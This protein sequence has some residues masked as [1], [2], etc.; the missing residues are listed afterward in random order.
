MN[1]HRFRPTLVM[2][3][4]MAACSA[5]QAQPST[6]DAS[7]S[8][9]VG[10]ASGDAAGR[11]LFGQYNGLRR[12]STI[13]LLDAEY[14]R[15]ND[16]AG[17]STQ[18]SA[19]NLL[20][21]T[22]E[23]RFGW[24]H[25]GDWKFAAHY[26][27]GVREDPLAASNGSE[28]K[29]TRTQFGMTYTKT[30]SRQ[31]QLELGLSSEKKE[32]ARLFGIGFSCPSSLAPTCRGSTGTETGWALLMLPEPIDA[33]HGQIEARLSFAGEQLRASVGYHASFYRNAL[34]S[35]QP[36]VPSSLN[37]ALGDLLPLSSG[38]Q[39]IL[40]QP[41]ALPP[42][43]QAHQLDVL[44]SY[45]LAPTTH[46]NFKL[47]HAR[48]T[49][50]QD[51]AAAGL[52][53]APSGVANL[54]ARVD[55]TLAQLGLS[56]RPWPKL[57]L[58]ARLRYEERDDSTPLALYNVEGSA[59][60]TNRQ[61][62]G[63]KW[64]ANAQA[65]YQ[66]TSD[67]RGSLG[68]DYEAIDRGVFTPTSAVAGIS[69][70]RQKTDETGLRAEL[71]RRMNENLSGAIVLATS[72]RKG[73][74]WLRDNSGLGVTEVPDASDPA[75]GLTNGIFMPT[76]AD[77]R[78][79]TL[80]L[81]A[82][83]QP[84]DEL[85]LQASAQSGFDR[86]TTPSVYGLR[87]SGNDQINLDANYALSERWRFNANLGWANQ[88]LR[89]ARPGGVTLDYDNRSGSFGLGL[90]G[91]PVAKLE[92]GAQLAYVDDRS[93]Y[94]QAADAGTAPADA[95]LLAATGGL[96]DI[97]FRQAVWTLYG[98][99]ELDKRS[100]VRLDL[101]HQRSTWTDWAWGYNGVPFSYSDGTTLSQQPHQRASFLG[102]RYIHRWP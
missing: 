97:V 79:D 99:Y 2:L 71:R 43:N 30:L 82:D 73:S 94:A 62:P 74:N 38:L 67:L 57:S 54:G 95:A 65:N 81:R 48:A 4:V 83:W 45:A 102:L 53:G 64:R 47:A 93:R 78:R 34:G 24:K 76:L 10:A 68:A 6:M 87:K 56:A 1:R 25:Q 28:L 39:A 8:V 101:V 17:S 11:A 58:Q 5:A 55:T 14:D 12:R 86:F 52:S 31:W 89:Q 51:F 36:A 15:R 50:H 72:R 63:S 16:E 29:L 59:S 40:N 66:F 20:G 13:G 49:Q 98:R 32:G 9:G 85:S 61:L 18:F 37:N 100:E 88:T 35:L 27:D 7:V 92:I 69:A 75:A 19:I 77:R 42:D 44:G 23:L 3:A 84:S 41:V 96:P 22:R 26:S 33:R 80:K 90:I 91:K 70:L 46:L 21:D 60:Y